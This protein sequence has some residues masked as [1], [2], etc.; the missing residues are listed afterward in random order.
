MRDN[1]FTPTYLPSSVIVHYN[2]ELKKCISGLHLHN[3][4]CILEALPTLQEKPLKS[5]QVKHLNSLFI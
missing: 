4:K 5:I 1:N 2:I 3:R